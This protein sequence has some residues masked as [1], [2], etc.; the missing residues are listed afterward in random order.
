MSA[1][2]GA[3]IADAE[4]LRFAQLAD[5]YINNYAS[6]VRLACLL[7]GSSA[8]A[9]EVVQDAYLHVA[10]VNPALADDRVLYSYLRTAIVNGC[11]HRLRR[12][13]VL[14][15]K[16]RLLWQPQADSDERGLRNAQASEAFRR[17]AALPKRQREAVV[18]RY[19]LDMSTADIA[20]T[21]GISEGAVKGYL[22]RAVATLRRELEE[23]RD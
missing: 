9:E 18:C 13:S 6:F 12:L 4:A 11:R 14:A 15:S 3:P 1:G 20:A 7:L 8:D 17:V 10:K 23:H 2:N 22:S 5:I 21:L 19:Y 16:Y